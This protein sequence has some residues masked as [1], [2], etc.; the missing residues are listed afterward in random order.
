MI[1]FKKE[2]TLTVVNEY[3]EENDNIVDENEETFKAGELVDGDICD[4]DSDG[5]VNIQFGDGGVAF[6][7]QRKCFTVVKK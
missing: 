1:K 6:G 4:D 2:T 7:V 3:D 5:Y